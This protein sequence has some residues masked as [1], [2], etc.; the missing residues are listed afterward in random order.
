[1]LSDKSVGCWRKG[2]LWCVH[3]HACTGHTS[4]MPIT[5]GMTVTSGLK[6]KLSISPST[7]SLSLCVS[8]LSV[9][10]CFVPVCVCCIYLPLAKGSPPPEL[11]EHHR[12]W[13]VE[14]GKDSLL[15]SLTEFY[16]VR[17]YFTDPVRLWRALAYCGTPERTTQS[18]ELMQ[19]ARGIYRVNVLG[20]S[21]TQR[22]ES[23]PFTPAPSPFGQSLYSV[24]E[25]Q[26]LGTM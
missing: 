13:H 26:P 9:L 4:Y 7:C 12:K 16:N 21:Y 20:P 14:G 2:K 18:Q 25:Q 3:A 22:R 8:D 10:V 23:D 24:S 6:P 5:H 1:M 19:K 15:E 11:V 17:S